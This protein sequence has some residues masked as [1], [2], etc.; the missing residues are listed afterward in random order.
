MGIQPR[1]LS[2]LRSFGTTETLRSQT[3]RHPGEPSIGLRHDIDHSIDVAL[4]LAAL[5]AHE[6]CAATYFVLHTAPYFDDPG[7]IDKLLQIQDYGHEIGL[8]LNVLTEW[9][10][11]QVDDVAAHLGAILEQLRSGGLEITGVS[12]HGDRSCYDNGFINYW[13][14]DALRP[15]SPAARE[16][17]RSAEGIH[18]DDPAY[19]IAYTG[20]TITRPDGRTFDLWSVDM[21][22]LGIDYEA[23]HLAFDAYY[24]DSGGSFKRTGDPIDVDL[25]DGRYQVLMHPWHWRAPQKKFFFLS[26]ARSGSTWLTRQLATSSSLVARHEHSLNHIFIG[27]EFVERKRTGPG[28]ASL[29]D[30]ASEIE[31]LLR[32]SRRWIDSHDRDYAEANV[33]LA[34]VIEPMRRVFSDALPIHLIRNPQAVVRSIMQRGWYSD[35]DDTKH[36]RFGLPRWDS[37]P[38]FEKAC[39]YVRL[40]NDALTALELPVVRLEDLVE[41]RTGLAEAM[42][43]L[44]IAVHPRFLVEFDAVINASDGPDFPAPSDWTARDRW[45]F[46]SICGPVQRAY[47][48]KRLRVSPP[49]VTSRGLH[50]LG[51]APTESIIHEKLDL[52]SIEEGGRVF[53]VGCTFEDATAVPDG[54]RH[55]YLLLGGGRWGRSVGDSGWSAQPG[56]RHR[57]TVTATLPDGAIAMLVA[58][59][60]DDQGNR[61]GQQTVGVLGTQPTAEFSFRTSPGATRMNIAV[62]MPHGSLPSRLRLDQITLERI[63][64]DQARLVAS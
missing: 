38:A 63:E 20:D 40:T 11:G 57:G 30:D 37:L 28:F 39:W 17:G 18:V 64:S 52:R 15:D 10:E 13:C 8:H 42:A 1:Y 4:E 49:K 58:L 33:Y 46:D 31:S 7:L 62:H 25:H 59:E 36:P 44:G 41:S 54:D 45:T 24:S 16:N 55:A 2:Y 19:Q 32:Q 14:L 3:R 21:A 56:V 27:R 26:T 50:E 61:I 9:F 60:F 22:A 34:H 5:D 29:V 43:E 35:P 51:S 47:G 6:G 48:Y 23:S 12:A 53:A